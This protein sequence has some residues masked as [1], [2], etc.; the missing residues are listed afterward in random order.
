VARLRA[1][2]ANANRSERADTHPPAPTAEVLAHCARDLV[3]VLHAA[4]HPL[5]M[6]EILDELVRR[7]LSWRENVVRHALLELLDQ[8]TV[9]EASD[10]RPHSYALRS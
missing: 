3:G 9:R 10:I 6:L 5:T 7:R 4:G 8:G 1:D 2:A